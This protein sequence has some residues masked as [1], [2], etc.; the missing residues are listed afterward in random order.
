MS[1]IVVIQENIPI[2]QECG[3]GMKYNKITQVYQCYTCGSR[4][5]VI[6]HGHSE[7]EFICET[8]VNKTKVTD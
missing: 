1:K 3:G 2:C 8:I 6:D 7:R 5:K 4:Y